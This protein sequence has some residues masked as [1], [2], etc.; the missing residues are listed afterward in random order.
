MPE[1]IIDKTSEKVVEPEK[2]IETKPEEKKPEENA[3]LEAALKSQETLNKILADGDFN[4][5]EELVE[6]IQKGNGLLSK[7][8]DRDLAAV[9]D[10]SATLHKYE[11]HWA[12]DAEAKKEE[13]EEP[14]D[15]IK[16]LKGEKAKAEKNLAAERHSQEEVAENVAA[17]RAFDSNVISVVDNEEVTDL[18]KPI[19]LRLLGV[20][21]P[22][23][24][25]DINN[26]SDV[27]KAA[28]SLIK[29]FNSFLTD[30]EKAAIQR[31]VDGKSKVETITKSDDTVSDTKRIP[32]NLDEAREIA[33]E[34]MKRV[35]GEN[36]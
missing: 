2:K 30:Y 24:A 27:K 29:D 21:N 35:F 13:G 6:S 32:K 11:D 8:G 34:G 14:E 16:R 10:D 25:V 33:R 4:S 22:M 31:Y 26:K 17:V 9:L 12:R 20:K 3:E 7:L 15:T 23:I 36:G 5:A 1:E 19:V 18:A 28:K